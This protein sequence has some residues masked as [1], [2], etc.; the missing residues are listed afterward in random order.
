M[1]SRRK[2]REYLLQILYAR[3]THQADFERDIFDDVFF[4]D[5]DMTLIDQNFIH[6]LEKGIL[7]NER[8]LLDTIAAL[9]PKF[10]LETMP[11]IHILI[12]VIALAE[13]SG[14]AEE[15]IPDTVS[16]NE[17]VELA[18]RFSDDQGKGFINGA[19]ATY[20]K[21]KEK[22]MLAKKTGTYNIFS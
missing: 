13:M 5:A 17:A 1:V 12:L 10:E 14:Y 3:A 20:L 8:T 22:I 6:H 19:L 16:T 7:A 2:T 18:K 9:A 21:D 4:E 15:E 11:V